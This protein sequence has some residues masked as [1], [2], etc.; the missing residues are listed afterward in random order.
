MP[1]T[2]HDWEESVCGKVK[3]ITTH[4]APVPLGNHVVTISYHDANLFYNDITGRSFAGVLRM[5]SKTP[6]YWHSKK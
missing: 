6:I 2:P 3:E 5:L 4:D 1:A